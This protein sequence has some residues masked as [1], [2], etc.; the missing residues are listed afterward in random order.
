M[1]NGPLQYAN[2]YEFAEAMSQQFIAVLDCRI[3]CHHKLGQF[4]SDPLEGDF[5]ASYFNYLQYGYHWSE[6]V[7][8]YNSS[9]PFLPPSIPLSLPHFLLSIPV[10][11]S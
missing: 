9:T 5:L 4:R 6:L 2:N 8:T 7:N 10:P 3:T 11:I 1:C